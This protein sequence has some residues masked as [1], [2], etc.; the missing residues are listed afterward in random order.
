VKVEYHRVAFHDRVGKVDPSVK[1][2][3]A[4]GMQVITSHHHSR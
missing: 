4:S 2:W 3:L 1:H